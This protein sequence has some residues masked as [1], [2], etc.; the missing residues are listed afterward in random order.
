MQFIEAI[1]KYQQSGDSVVFTI[2]RDAMSTDYMNSQT[3]MKFE[4]PEMYVAFRCLRLLRGFLATIKYTLTD[5]GLHS[6]RDTPEHIFSEFSAAIKG[7]TG[8]DLTV[9]NFTEHEAYL[10]KYLPTFNDL[11]RAYERIIGVRPTLWQLFTEEIVEENW[12]ELQKA[13]E[14]AIRRVDT[15]R[16]ER[17]IV[18]YI[19]CAT[20]TAYYRNQFE[21]MRRVRRGG[22][23]R[24]VVPNYYGPIYTIFGRA[25]FDLDSLTKRQFKLIDRIIEIVREDHTKGETDKYNVDL[26]GGYRIK[27]RYI[28]DRIGVHEVSLSRALAKIKNVK[29]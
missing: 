26:R 12:I 5:Y 19:N 24:Y 7:W 2:I 13:L 27:N 14:Y 18:R 11:R 4:K 6:S 17:E 16:S 25:N 29:E 28:A 23:T 8:I 22:K 10:S 1:Q 3:G 20:R 9:E 15:S 21:G